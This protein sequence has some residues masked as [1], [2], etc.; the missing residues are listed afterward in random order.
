M[1]K[2]LTQAD[3]NDL[4]RSALGKKPSELL[5]SCLQERY[6]LMP[7]V[8][9]TSFRNRNDRFSRILEVKENS[10]TAKTLDFSASMTQSIILKS[11]AVQ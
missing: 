8:N 6:L 5:G 2:L 9:I 7:D 11:G 10:A 3:L 1:P 4:V